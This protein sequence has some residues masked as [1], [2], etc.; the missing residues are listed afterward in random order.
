MM[1][2][3]EPE[4]CP[5]YGE[6][7]TVITDLWCRR[8]GSIVVDL[9]YYLQLKDEQFF[10]M[11]NCFKVPDSLNLQVVRKLSAQNCLQIAPLFCKRYFERHYGTRK[12][13]WI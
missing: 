8:P 1:K 13:W 12:G 11:L 3:I 10:S 9:V 5:Q 7:I 6:E 2:S 4:R